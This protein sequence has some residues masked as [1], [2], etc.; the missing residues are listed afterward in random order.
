MTPTLHVGQKLKWDAMIDA[1]GQPLTTTVRGVCG[2]VF[3]VDP[4]HTYYGPAQVFSYLL[5]DWPADL[6]KPESPDD[7]IEEWT[8]IVVPLGSGRDVPHRKLRSGRVEFKNEYG[9]WALCCCTDAQLATDKKAREEA[10]AKAAMRD[11][12][13]TFGTM[14]FK[15]P[16][17]T[18]LHS[19]SSGSLATKVTIR[20]VK[21]LDAWE[22]NGVKYRLLDTGKVEEWTGCGSYQW[23]AAPER[24]AAERLV[25]VVKSTRKVLDAIGEATGG[26]KK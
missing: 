26:Q 21:T 2:E 1:F 18:F 10:K 13:Y 15:N 24:E 23:V 5:S 6:V 14:T 4:P 8:P 22:R 9:E 11:E 7:V 3:H 25:T 20:E 16:S 17:I 19:L 12:P